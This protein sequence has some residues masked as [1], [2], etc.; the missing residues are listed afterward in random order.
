MIRPSE[1]PIN[2]GQGRSKADE[3]DRAGI[4]GGG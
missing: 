4:P 3:P 1:I 2:L